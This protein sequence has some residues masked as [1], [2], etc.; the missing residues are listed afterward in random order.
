M[1]TKY[2]GVTIRGPE[3][4]QISFSYQGKRCREIIRLPATE[5]NIKHAAKRRDIILYEIELNRFDYLS[6]F[7]HTKN[8]TAL[9]AKGG[10]STTIEEALKSWLIT[11]QKSHAFSTVRD[12]ESSVYYHLIP[13]FGHFTLDEITRTDIQTWMDSL[14]ISNK[15]INNILIPLRQVLDLAYRDELIEKNPMTL[16]K[17]RKVTPREPQPFTKAEITAI[18]NHLEGSPK[19]AVQFGFFSGVRTSE[20]IGLKWENVNL[21]EGTVM[22][23]EACVRGKMKPPKTTSGIRKLN[24]EPEAL[25]ALEAQNNIRTKSPFVFIDTKSGE[26]WKSDQPFRKRIWIPALRKA[27]IEYREPYQMRHTYA[28]HMLSRGCNQLKLAQHMG[29]R[30][31]GMIR[32]VYGRWLAND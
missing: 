1:K 8:K 5:A 18:L 32:K 4:I 26:R 27:Q 6:H 23:K 12:Y 31:F 19:Y 13:R 25:K 20:L 3:A 7:P 15:R 2:R 28:S 16:I 17:N 11:A 24:L 10:C 30:D 21:K 29:H 22:I 9:A 14:M